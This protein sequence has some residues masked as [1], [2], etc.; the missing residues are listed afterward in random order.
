MLD[1]DPVLSP[2]KRRSPQFWTHVYC[3]QTAAWIKMPLRTEVGLGPGDFCVHWGPSYPQKKGTPTA[4]FLAHVYCGQ[5]AGKMKT[6]LG[7]EV[8]LVPGH[9]VLDVV[10][11]VR[12]RG[13]AAPPPLFIH[14][15]SGHGRPSQLLLSSCRPKLTSNALSLYFLWLP[16]VAGAYITFCSCGYFLLLLRVMAALCNRTGHCIFALRF[17]LF[18]LMV[19]LWNRADHYIFALWLLLSSLW[20]PY[21]IGGPSPPKRA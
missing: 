17:L 12:E 6:P 21:V 1:G 19:A 9:I 20:P 8:D 2:R 13:T 3:G 10:P 15:Y 18:L 4:Q 7:T 16:C 11:V 14:V 5:T